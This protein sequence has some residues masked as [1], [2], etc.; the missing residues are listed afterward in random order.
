[1]QLDPVGL[2]IMIFVVLGFTWVLFKF[3]PDLFLKENNH[4]ANFTKVGGK[5]LK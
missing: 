4:V 3:L 1:M 2:V 5:K